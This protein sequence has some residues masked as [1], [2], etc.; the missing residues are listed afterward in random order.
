MA[1]LTRR[2]FVQVAGMTAAAVALAACSNNAAPAGDEPTDEGT[3]P[4]ATTASGDLTAPDASA[5]PIDPDPEGTEALWTS[6]ETRDGWTRFTNP[7]GKTLGVKDTAK[8]IQAGGFAFKDLDGTG[9]LDLYEDWRQ[10]AE[11]RAAA[12]AA[13]LT[14]EECIKL[15]WHGGAEDHSEGA[16]DPDFGLIPQGSTAGVSRLASNAESFAAD[17]Q[18]VN[19]V[20]EMCEAR[21]YCMP[22]LNSTDPYQ[23]FD[24]PNTI[25]LASAMDKDLW[26]RAGMWISRAWRA[27]GVRLELG[28]QLDLYTTPTPKRVDGAVT[29][30]PAVDRDFIQAFGGG[31]QSSWGDDNATDDLGWGDESVA[32]MLKHFAG[33][34]P[35]ETGADDHYDQGKWGVF[36]NGNYQAH[37]LPFLD[38]GLNLD[39]STG[40]M[41]AVMTN[42]GISYSPDKE[43]GEYVGGGYN[44]KQIGILRNTGWEGMITSDWG[45][46]DRGARGVEDLSRSERYEKMV[47]AGVDQYGGNHEPD[48]TGA[49]AYELLKA[50]LGDDG[51]TDRVH[52]SARRILTLMMRVDLFEQP[53]S[54]RAVA[55]EVFDNAAAAAFG[56]EAS[57]KAV[58]MLKNAEGI[59]SQAG[60]GENPKV[61]IPQTFVPA[62][63]GMHP[64]PSEIVS[65]FD[66]DVAA[67]YFDV[68]TDGVAD[69]TGDPMEEGGDPM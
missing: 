51:A 61:Y 38:G 33:A 46:L 6:E 54:E 28:P 63:M 35:I 23:L 37:L 27:T 48:T 53:Y 45:I 62:E 26:R 2:N 56:I 40:Q 68:V 57:E 25:G 69:P 11:D 24:I 7:G 29:E 52:E 36:P 22:Y 21:P 15:M 43:Y 65:S 10:S 5:Y 3:E 44:K 20:Q 4:E 55:K 58:V 59:I 30:D 14:D 19:T 32:V 16:T 49:E 64:K 13:A 60:L 66:A 67:K 41:A 31:M 18:W 50:E 9:T 8:I 42:Y 17:I 47:W 34:G 1:Q 39:S 12:L